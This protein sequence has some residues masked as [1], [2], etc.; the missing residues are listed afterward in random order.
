MGILTLGKKKLKPI[1][2]ALHLAQTTF[3]LSIFFL[4][5]RSPPSLCLS[6]GELGDP[7]SALSLSPRLHLS[8]SQSF[9]LIPTLPLSLDLSL[10][11]SSLTKW[12]PQLQGPHALVNQLQRVSKWGALAPQLPKH[13]R[14][15][16]QTTRQRQ[17]R[18]DGKALFS[19]H[20]HCQFMV[21]TS[22]P[23]IPIQ[24]STLRFL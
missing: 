23:Q 9:S 20:S 2:E 14:W 12:G 19:G 5:P 3:S 24:D 11:L 18:N 16:H 13:H 15:Q 4:S 7:P 6:S 10:S 17:R 8:C 22:S 21:P 1:I